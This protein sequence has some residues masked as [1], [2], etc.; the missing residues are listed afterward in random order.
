MDMDTFTHRTAP[1]RFVDVEGTRFAYRRFGRERGIPL[2]LFQ[3]LGGNLDNWDPAVTDG[4]ANQREVILFDNRGVASTGGRTPSTVAEM[5]RDAELFIDA[6]ALPKVDV[7]GFSLGGFIAQIV[8]IDRPDLVRRIVLV[9][10]GPRNGESMESLTP[11]G[12]AIFEKERA[13][14]DELW[15]DCFFSASEASQRAGRSF[16]K[17]LHDRTMDRDVD[18]APEVEPAQLA[19]VDEWGRALPGAERFAYLA[20]ITQPTLVVEGKNDVV[21]YTINSFLLQQ[22]LPNA[23]LVLYPD[24]SHGSLFQFP[25]LFVEHVNGFL[26]RDALS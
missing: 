5:A 24:A 6:L 11:E 7:L 17:R 2:V 3:H 20:Q 22:H 21:V 13:N 23:E 15:Q 10:T 12:R 9:G 26:D 4:L 14:T 25:E 8:P 1:T 18:L 19:A 16:V